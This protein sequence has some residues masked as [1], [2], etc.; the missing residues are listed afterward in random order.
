MCGIAGYCGQGVDPEEAEALLHRMTGAI[1]HRGPDDAGIHVGKNAGLGHRRLSVVGIADGHQPMA[2]VD[3]GLCISFNGEIFNHIE[4]RKALAAKGHVFK[5]TSDTEVILHLY[6]EIGADCVTQLN[7]D[8]AFA[9]WDAPRRRMML[10]RDRMGV[11]PLFHSWHQGTFYFASEVKA[12]LT[13]P[14][15]TAEID[16]IALDQIFTL[17]APIAP[18]TMFKGIAE[19]PPAHLML[20]EGGQTTIRPY[21]KLE[22]PDRGD[23]GTTRPQEDIAAELRD[24]LEDAT[25][26]RLRADVPVGSYLSGELDSSLIS[27]LAAPLVPAGLRTFSVTFDGAEYDEGP[28]QRMMAEHLGTRHSA[29]ACHADDIAESFPQVVRHMERPVLRT[30]PAPLYLLANLVREQGFK[31][32]LTGE[33]A[34]EIFAGYDLFREAR[35]RRFCARQPTSSIRPTLFR[36]LY[37]YLPGLAQQTPAYLAAFFDV[38]PEALG[39]PLYSHHPRMR[40]TAAAKMFFSAELRETLGAYDAAEELA[41]GLPEAFSRWDP[42]HQAQY[43]ETS[44]LLPGYILSSQGDRVAMAS[45]VEGRFPFLDHRLVEFAARIPPNM[46]LNG[47]REK[48]ILKK[49]AKDLVPASIIARDKQPYRAPESQSFLGSQ[50]PSYVSECLSPAA[51]RQA[52]LFNAPLVEKLVQK[53]Q[54]RPMAGFRD[55]AAFVGILST[56]LWVDSFARKPASGHLKQTAA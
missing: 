39:D 33:G 30:A 9:L 23:L 8:F 40:N 20:V 35:L 31:V 28:F 7:G 38:E 43:I 32:V 11:R 13:V 36:K 48:H 37:P 24:L 50:A 55:N 3:G 5:T 2:S 15:I 14:G 29:V 51:I 18:R 52:G 4:L 41:A 49:A 26:I 10:A 22:F 44:F 54:R 47:L 25:R 16:P 27:A 45:G 34:D 56:Q 17:W 46:K 19:L 42:L 1:A 21:W 6:Q 12:L 53:G